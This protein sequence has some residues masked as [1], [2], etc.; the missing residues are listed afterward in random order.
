MSHLGEDVFVVET[1]FAGRDGVE[2]AQRY[3][4]VQA[5]RGDRLSQPRYL[6]PEVDGNVL[7]RLRLRE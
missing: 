1:G 2:Y 7:C 3:Q 4:P 6:A 5:L